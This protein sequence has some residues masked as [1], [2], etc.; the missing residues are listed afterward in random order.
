VILVGLFGKIAAGKSVLASTLADHGAVVVDAD[1]VAHQ[2]LQTP[3]V[4]EALAARFGRDLLDQEGHIRRSVLAAIVFRPGPEAAQA[5]ED[6][7]AL[8]HPLIRRRIENEIEQI[9]SSHS[10]SAEQLVI[11]L[12]IPLLVQSG[13]AD[14]C[15]RIIE[16]LCNEGVRV[17]RLQNR[18]WSA[19]MIAQRDMAWNRKMPRQPLR[20]LDQPD[21]I[22]TVDTSSEIS[23]TD[24]EV[25]RIWEWL[26]ATPR[27]ETL[28]DFP[29]DNS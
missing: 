1:R 8:V 20:D 19:E 15:D 26:R 2:V 5:L 3:E 6:L 16:V 21:K 7:E 25:Q 14:R 18:G 11:V 29:A 28:K 22:R 12:D 9:R 4:C 17:E 23:Y 24:E 27:S 13:W 10:T